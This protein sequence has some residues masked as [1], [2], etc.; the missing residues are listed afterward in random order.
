MALAVIF[1]R[2]FS[3]NEGKGKAKRVKKL[4]TSSITFGDEVSQNRCERDDSE[5]LVMPWKLMQ[6]FLREHN[7]RRV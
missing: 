4:V 1:V 3:E 6:T 7:E 2:E 5:H